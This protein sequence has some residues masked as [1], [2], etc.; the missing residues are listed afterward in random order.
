MTVCVSLE[1][2]K[3]LGMDISAIIAPLLMARSM[4]CQNRESFYLNAAM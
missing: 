2:L 4:A 3:Y 1:E